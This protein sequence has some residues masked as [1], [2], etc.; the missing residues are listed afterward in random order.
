MP[1]KYEKI[2]SVEMQLTKIEHTLITLY[3]KLPRH[4]RQYLRR[5]LVVMVKAGLRRQ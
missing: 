4:D 3:R 5:V 1:E 2:A